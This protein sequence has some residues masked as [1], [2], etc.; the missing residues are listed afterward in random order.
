MS[1][2]RYVVY[3]I[4][5]GYVENLILLNPKSNWLPPVGCE[6]ERI[7]DKTMVGIGWTRESKLVYIAPVEPVILPTVEEVN[8]NNQKIIESLNP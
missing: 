3:R 4:I 5:D 8:E 1:E 6:I 7:E 2:Y